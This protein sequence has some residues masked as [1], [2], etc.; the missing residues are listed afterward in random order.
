MQIF[1]YPA[2]LILSSRFLFVPMTLDQ[3]IVNINQRYKLG[4]ATEHIV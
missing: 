2:S 4:N 1:V 3:Y